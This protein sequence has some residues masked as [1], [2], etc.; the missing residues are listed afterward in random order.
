MSGTVSLRL[1]V[2]PLS[3]NSSIGGGKRGHVVATMRHRTTRWVKT[4]R[5]KENQE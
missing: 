1:S 3:R 2:S 5:T 4:L